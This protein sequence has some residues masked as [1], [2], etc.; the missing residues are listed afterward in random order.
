MMIFPLELQSKRKRSENGHDRCRSERLERNLLVEAGNQAA[1]GRW[2]RPWCFSATRRILD[3]V[4][5]SLLLV[6]FSP[7]F[8]VIAIAIKLGPPGPVFFCQVR[9]G[10]AGQR[11]K[12]YK[13]RS[14]RKD[15][16]QLKQA[17]RQHNHH[18]Q[19]S[20]DFKM[21]SDPRVTPVGR[22]LRK[23]SVDELP[24]LINVVRGEMSIVGPRPTSFDIDA[25]ADWH[26]A[27]LAVPPGITG[28]A[29]I[30]GRGDV[31]FDDRVVLDCRYIKEQSIFLD[32]KILSVTPFCI[33]GGILTGRGVY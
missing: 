6:L 31:D 5:A 10:L 30:S 18:S 16:E 11:F 2:T 22:I 27:R 19:S 14:M 32:L 23:L 25:Y 7:I 15:A 9:T 21:K 26:L 1:R 33:L 20:P 12:V 8:L 4:G 29:Q 24:N 28:L 3:I 17:L 13:F